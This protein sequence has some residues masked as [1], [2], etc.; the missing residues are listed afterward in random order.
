M[1]GS[2]RGTENPVAEINETA[3]RIKSL[4]SSNIFAPLEASSQS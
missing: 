1:Q 4:V 2:H 3:A